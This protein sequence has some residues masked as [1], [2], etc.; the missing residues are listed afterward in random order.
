MLRSNVVG[1]G[2][3]GASHL[4]LP[5]ARLEEL[6]A[7]LMLNILQL[8]MFADENVA[9]VT[10]DVVGHAAVAFQDLR[11]CVAPRLVNWIS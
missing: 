10:L 7:K 4:A 3:R 1:L 9:S 5:H 11:S 6:Q 2:R 8:L